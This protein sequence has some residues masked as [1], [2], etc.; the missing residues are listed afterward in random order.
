MPIFAALLHW[1]AGMAVAQKRE[2][3]DAGA[4]FLVLVEIEQDLMSRFRLLRQNKLQVVAERRLD[5]SH[6]LVGHVDTV[7]Q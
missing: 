2:R 4:A 5:R 3:S 6:V 1:R 7:G